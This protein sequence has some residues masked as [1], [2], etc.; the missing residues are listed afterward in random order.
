MTTKVAVVSGGSRGLGEAI[1]EKLLANGCSVATFSRCSTP[2]VERALQRYPGFY[3]ESLEATDRARLASFIESVRTRLGPVEVLVNNAGVALSGLLTLSD[4][5]AI[6]ACIELNVGSVIALTRL[7]V[8]H[9]LAT[10]RGTIVN[11]SS[12]NAVRGHAG[13]AVY[14][15]TKGAL[16]AF[17]RSLARELGPKGI[18]VNSVAPGYIETRMVADLP[19]KKRAAIV[20][21]T[22]LGRLGT[23]E[24][25][26]GVVEFLLSEHARFVTGQVVVVDG[27]FTC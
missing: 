6:D 1:V 15:A 21:R 2:F 10:E 24:D 22:P 3:W 23:V 11:V 14:S 26:V 20:R 27:G 9:M 17:T 13:V 5:D 4:A 19:P 8:R 25:V 18:R 7:C 12:V 16:D